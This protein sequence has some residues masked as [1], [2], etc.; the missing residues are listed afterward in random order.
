MARGTGAS[1][2]ALESAARLVA[3]AVERERCVEE[4]AHMQALRESEALKTSLLRAISHD[5][6]TPITAVTI[7]TE[8]MRRRAVADPEMMED[9]NS[10]AEETARLRRRI[11]NLLAM[12]RLESGKAKPRREP[13]PPADL[14]RAARENLP[15]VFGARPMAVHVDPD[16]P[17]ANVDPS[18]ALE[19]LANLIE[20]A[21]RVSPEG[22]PIELVARRHP[23]DSDKVRIE[24][25]DR[26]PGL[27]PGVAD[28][29]GNIATEISDVA[30]RGLGLEIA[31]S[32]AAANGGSI[33]LAPR[34]G[35]G[36]IARI[37]LP[38]AP[39]PVGERA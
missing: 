31:R 16:C 12:A 37:D 23:L 22:V 38:A 26:G 28:A 30:Q 1:K 17:D 9:I 19:I 10:I 25:L 36:T 33:G 15:L 29:D 5:L 24:I 34:P 14:F 3:L 35:G 27:P 18:L 4:N 7:R 21:D 8:S 2:Q 6:T 39:V 13:T 32:L 11:D 20:N